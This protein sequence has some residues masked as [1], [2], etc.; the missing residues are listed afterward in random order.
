MAE[1]ER[2][3]RCYEVVLAQWRALR[4]NDKVEQTEAK[5]AELTPP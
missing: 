5:V 4:R 1:A 2:A 3:L